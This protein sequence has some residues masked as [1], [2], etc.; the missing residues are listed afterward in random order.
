[1]VAYLEISSYEFLKHFIEQ[2]ERYKLNREYSMAGTYFHKIIEAYN[3]IKKLRRFLKNQ[4]LF[5]KFNEKYGELNKG[6]Q[7]FLV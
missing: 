4:T 6:R 7:V 1:M 5:S 2:L 3:L